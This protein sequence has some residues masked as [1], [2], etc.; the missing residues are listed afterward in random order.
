MSNKP[1]ELLPIQFQSEVNK[2]FFENTVDQ[3]FQK[4]NTEVLDGFIGRKISGTDRANTSNF[5]QQNDIGRNFYSLEP[6]FTSIDATSGTPGN[7][8]FYE[9]LLFSL[10]SYNAFVNNH[11]RLFKAKE[12][13]YS[14]PIDIDKFVNYQNYFWIPDDL[15]IVRIYGTADSPINIDDI[16]GSKTFVAPNGTELLNGS[17]VQFTGN[18][19]SGSTFS[20]DTTYQVEG[21]GQHIQ[22]IVPNPQNK[23]SAY[24][25]FDSVAWDADWDGIGAYSGAGLT[26]DA[27]NINPSLYSFDNQPFDA[28]SNQRSADYLVL[29][30]GAKNN[31]PWSRLNYWYH[32]DT[33]KQSRTVSIQIPNPWDTSSYDSTS[34]D[35]TLTEGSARGSIP[36]GA[37]RAS[38]PI[39]EFN[40]DLELY[41][42][43]KTHTGFV[44]LVIN[45]PKNQ[46]DGKIPMGYPLNGTTTAVGKQVIFTANESTPVVYDIGE[47]SNSNVTVTAN[48]NISIST[49]DTFV[50]SEGADI[51]A[52]YYW[53]GSAWTKAQFKSGVNLAPKFNLYD[54]N[55]VCLSNSTVYPSN[56]FKGNEIFSY[57]L[58]AANSNDS[59]LG[60]K[61]D[62]RAGKY[63]S[64]ILYENDIT[65]DSYIYTP[66][67]S[68]TSTVIPGYYYAKDNTFS[69]DGNSNERF[70][71]SWMPN[72]V[73]SYYLKFETTRNY[74]QGTTVE[75]NNQFFEANANVTAGAFDIG[76]WNL[77]EEKYSVQVVQDEYFID[78]TN[79]DETRFDISATPYNNDVDVFL[80]ARKLIKNTD[81]SIVANTN[82]IVLTDK[83]NYGDLL[84]I[85]TQTKGN[86]DFGREGRFVIPSA[87]EKNTENKSVTE[88]TTSDVLNHFLSIISD[89]PTFKGN[90]LGVNNFINS[91]KIHSGNNAKIRQTF[92]D[93]PS[94]MFFARGSVANFIEALRYSEVEYTK[95][96]NRLSS[97]TKAYLE[98][99]DIQGK[100]NAQL[101]EEIYSEIIT[102]RTTNEAFSR[103]YMLPWGTEFESV[104]FTANSSTTFT[105]TVDA[106]LQQMNNFV[107]VY[108]NKELLVADTDYTVSSSV[109]VAI[110]LTTVSSGDTIE[111]K[112][113]QD[114]N[115]SYIP[116]TPSTLGLHKLYKPEFK[117]DSTYTDS[118]SVIQGHDGSY[119]AR[120]NTK[121]DDIILHFEKLVYNSVLQ[122]VRDK[123]TVNPF[124]NLDSVKPSYFSNTDYSRQEINT[125]L[126]EGFSRWASQNNVDFVTNSTLDTNN[127]FTWNYGELGHWR[128]VYEYYYDTQTPHTT[129][130]E[131]FGFSKKPSWWES[132]YG[133]TVTTSSTALWNNV[134]TGYIPQGDRKGYYTRYKRENITSNLPVDSSGNLLAPNVNVL[135]GVVSSSDDITKSWRFGDGAPAEQA[136][137][138][139]S[140]YPFA[141]VKLLFLARPGE[142]IKYYNDVD[143]II[144]PSAMPQQLVD[145]TTRKRLSHK[146]ITYYGGLESDNET[147][148]L[149]LGFSAYVDSW[150]LYQN[151]DSARQ[152]QEVLQATDVKL[153]H[154]FSGY[155][156]SN[157]LKVYSDKLSIDGFS[158]GERVPA[159]DIYT[160]LHTS[161]VINR[162]FYTGVQVTK[163][164]D[165]YQVRG[166]DKGSNVFKILE[167]D[168]NGGSSEIKV[169]GEPIIPSIFSITG[170]YNKDDIISYNGNYYKAK[171]SVTAGDFNFDN[172]NQITDLPTEG[173]QEGT[174]YNNTTGSV[175]EIQYGHTFSSANATFDFLISLGRYQESIGFE[176]GDYDESI[177]DVGNW[178]YSAKQ[179]LFWVDSNPATNTVSAFSPNA[180]KLRFESAIGTVNQINKFTKGI[181]SIVDADGK[182]LEPKECEISRSG[183]YLEI[184][185]PEGKSIYGVILQTSVT[186]HAMVI[187]NKSV[188][189][190][191]IL[192]DIYGIRQERLRLKTQRSLEWDGSLKAPGYIIQGRNTLPNFDSLVE[193]T[194][195]YH[196]LFDNP[197]LPIKRTLARSVFGY[198]EKDYLNNLGIDDDEQ[199]ELL[200]GA[201]R[202][203]GTAR[204]INRILRSD[205]INKNKDFT[206]YEEWAVKQGVFGD[207]GSKKSFDIILNKKD[208]IRDQ[209]LIE[210][211]YPESV[212]GIV[213]SIDI[214]ER[215]TQY[216]APPIVE[217]DPP[218]LAVS[219]LSGSGTG[220]A[221][222]TAVLG[223]D[224]TLSSITMDYKGFGYDVAPNV[225]IITGN[226]YVSKIDEVLVNGLAMSSSRVPHPYSNVGLGNIQILDHTVSANII[227]NVAHSTSLSNLVG[228]INTSISSVTGANVTAATEFE[229]VNG[230]M[231]L[232]LAGY[233]FT[234]SDSDGGTTLSY[235][236]LT[237]GRYQPK[238]KFKIEVANNT[239][240]NNIVTTIDGTN[241]GTS[242][243]SFSD[244]SRHTVNSNIALYN[245]YLANDKFSVFVD[246]NDVANNI[247]T[248]GD[249]YEYV[250]V[251]VDGV[252]IYNDSDYTRLTVSNAG[253]GKANIHLSN[254][255]SQIQFTTS[256]QIK[257]IEEA[258]ITFDTSLTSDVPGSNVEVKVESDDKLVAIPGSTRTYA[259]DKDDPTDNVVTIDID[260]AKR[261][262]K[263][264]TTQD[265]N[266][267]LYPT[268]RFTKGSSLIKNSGFVHKDNVDIQVF[269]INHFDSE[270]SSNTNILLN[271]ND[272]VHM[273]KGEHDNFDVYQLRS[274]QSR[275]QQN[276]FYLR[277][278]EGATTTKLFSPISLQEFND[279]NSI[280]DPLNKKYY[281]NTLFLKNSNLAN[282][283]VKYTNE[284]LVVDNKSIYRGVY[285]PPPTTQGLVT[286]IQPNR[287]A[288]IKGVYPDTTSEFK[289]ISLRLVNPNGDLSVASNVGIAGNI[290]GASNVAIG[291]EKI[292]GIEDDSVIR[293]YGDDL[294][295][296]GLSNG[297]VKS[298]N[299]VSVVHDKN[300]V[301][302]T[303]ANCNNKFGQV[304]GLG[305]INVR[306]I[307]TVEGSSNLVDGSY[308]V[309]A[310]SS[311]LNGT[312]LTVNV[313]IASS[314]VSSIAIVNPGS[315][316]VEDEEIRIPETS[317]GGSD[318]NV[319]V[320]SNITGVRDDGRVI[321]DKANIYAVISNPVTG[322]SNATI[323]GFTFGNKTVKFTADEIQDFGNTND[324]DVSQGKNDTSMSMLNVYGD[325]S[326]S[327]VNAT[328]STFTITSANIRF[329]DASVTRSATN[330]KLVSIGANADLKGNASLTLD[331]VLPTH[332]FVKLDSSKA[333][334]FYPLT[335]NTSN[336]KKYHFYDNGFVS[337]VNGNTAFFT[338]EITTQY[339]TVSSYDSANSQFVLGNVT[340][341]ALGT[342]FANV[343]FVQANTTVDSDIVGLSTKRKSLEILSSTTLA[344]PDTNAVDIVPSF[345][346]SV[347]NDT[348]IEANSNVTVI[349]FPTTDAQV[350]VDQ[351]I[352]DMATTKQRNAGISDIPSA[353]SYLTTANNNNPSLQFRLDGQAGKLTSIDDVTIGFDIKYLDDAQDKAFKLALED[354]TGEDARRVIEHYFV[355]EAKKI[356]NPSLENISISLESVG[357]NEVGYKLI[358]DGSV[359]KINNETNKQVIGSVTRTPSPVMVHSTTKGSYERPGSGAQSD[360]EIK[361]EFSDFHQMPKTSNGKVLE[362]HSTV[363]RINPNSN[364]TIVDRFKLLQT[365]G[366][367]QLAPANETTL[368]DLVTKIN[369]GQRGFDGQFVIKIEFKNGDSFTYDPASNEFIGAK[370]C[371]I[372]VNSLK[373]NYSITSNEAGLINDIRVSLY[374][375]TSNINIAHTTVKETF[376]SGITVEDA[377]P[378]NDLTGNVKCVIWSKDSETGDFVFASNFTGRAFRPSE[379]D[380][381]VTVGKLVSSDST[382][383]GIYNNF[384]TASVLNNKRAHN[385]D[386]MA[387]RI[388]DPVSYDPFVLFGTDLTPSN[389]KYLAVRNSG[390]E[391][392][393]AV[394]P[395]FKIQTQS[396]KNDLIVF[397]DTDGIN[398]AYKVYF[399]DLAFSGSSPLD[400]TSGF[401]VT[402]IEADK[403]I[404][405]G[406]THTAFAD[407]YHT[408]GTD[409][410]MIVTD[411]DGKHLLINQNNHNLRETDI[412]M[413]NDG[414]LTNPLNNTRFTVNQVQGND[415]YL[416][417]LNGATVPTANVANFKVFATTGQ[418][419]MTTEK[420]S[421]EA[422][423]FYSNNHKLL[424]GMQFTTYADSPDPSSFNSATFTVNEAYSTDSFSAE[425]SNISAFTND[426]ANLTYVVNSDKLVCNFLGRY[427]PQQDQKLVVYDPLDE[428][429]LHDTILTANVYYSQT[430]DEFDIEGDVAFD[431]PTP[432]TRTIQS[433]TLV[434][435]HYE[436]SVL[437]VPDHGMFRHTHITNAVATST[438]DANNN[439]TVTVNDVTNFTIGSNVTFDDA[440]ISHTLS[441]NTFV[442]IDQDGENNTF[443]ITDAN[444]TATAN[445]FRVTTD[446]YITNKER[447]IQ[448]GNT[449]FYDGFANP[450]YVTKDTISFKGRYKGTAEGWIT[451]DAMNIFVNGPVNEL[452]G[453][454]LLITNCPQEYY[455]RVY[456]VVS[457]YS[458][459]ESSNIFVVRGFAQNNQ[460][461]NLANSDTR[462][463]NTKRNRIRVNG[464]QIN[465]ANTDSMTNFVKSMNAEML[466]REGAIIDTEDGLH[467]GFLYGKRN[468]ELD[469]MKGTKY[470]NVPTNSS[471]LK[472]VFDVNENPYADPTGNTVLSANR[473]VPLNSVILEA[474]GPASK[475]GMPMLDVS[476]IEG[477]FKSQR[478]AYK[479]KKKIPYEKRSTNALD[480][481]AKNST[482]L[483]EHEKWTNG[484]VNGAGPV[485]PRQ[486]L[487]FKIRTYNKT[488]TD[489]FINDATTQ[490]EYASSPINPAFPGG[491]FPGKPHPGIPIGDPHRP[492]H[493]MYDWENH[494]WYQH[495]GRGEP[496]FGP[497]PGGG[498]GG[499]GAADGYGAGDWNEGGN[500]NNNGDNGGNGNQEG[501]GEAD[502][503]VDQQY[504]VE[505]AGNLCTQSGEILEFSDGTQVTL[506]EG[507]NVEQ[508]AALLASQNPNYTYVTNG[509]NQEPCEEL[510]AQS[511]GHASVDIRF[512]D[513]LQF[514]GGDNKNRASRPTYRE[515]IKDK[516]IITSKA[517]SRHSWNEWNM[518]KFVEA[519]MAIMRQE[520]I[521]PNRFPTKYGKDK[522]FGPTKGGVWI[523]WEGT[524]RSEIQILGQTGRWKKNGPVGY[525]GIGKSHGYIFFR[526]PREFF[527][528]QNYAGAVLGWKIHQK[529]YNI[530]YNK[531]TLNIGGGGQPVI[532]FPLFLSNYFQD[533]G[534]DGS[535]F[536]RKFFSQVYDANT[537]TYTT[538]H[539]RG[540]MSPAFRNNSVIHEYPR[541]TATDRCP[542]PVDPGAAVGT[543]QQVT[544]KRFLNS[545]KIKSNL[546]FSLAK[547]CSFGS[548]SECAEYYPVNERNLTTHFD[549]AKAKTE[550][551][552][553]KQQGL[554]DDTVELSADIEDPRPG[555]A[556]GEFATPTQLGI[557]TIYPDYIANKLITAREQ[558]N[559]KHKFVNGR[560]VGQKNIRDTRFV[561]LEPPEVPTGQLQDGSGFGYRIG[562]QLVATG[563]R[564][565]TI[566]EDDYL[567]ASVDLDRA[568]KL[569]DIGLTPEGN[570]VP[571]FD[572]LTIEQIKRKLT[573]EI[574]DTDANPIPGVAIKPVFNVT[575][576]Y[577]DVLPENEKRINVS[578]SGI[579]KIPYR[580]YI[581]SGG[582]TTEN[583]DQPD[584]EGIREQYRNYGLS[585]ISSKNFRIDVGNPTANVQT[586]HLTNISGQEKTY[587]AFIGNT[588]LQANFC[589]VGKVGF[590]QLF[591]TDSPATKSARL[592]SFD[593]EFDKTYNNDLIAVW[594]TQGQ[595]ELETHLQSLSAGTEGIWKMVAD[596]SNNPNLE[597]KEHLLTIAMLN[598]NARYMQF[599][600]FKDHRAYF[601]ILT[602]G[603][604]IPANQANQGWYEYDV[605]NLY[606]PKNNSFRKVTSRFY[607]VP[608]GTA[609]DSG[610]VG[611]TKVNHTS[612]SGGTVDIIKTRTL[613]TTAEE[614]RLENMLAFPEDTSFD[615]ASGVVTKDPTVDNSFTLD[616]NIR[617]ALINI[618]TTGDVSQ[619]SEQLDVLIIEEGIY[620]NF[621]RIPLT[622]HKAKGIEGE[623]D[624]KTP[625]KVAEDYNKIGLKNYLTAFNKGTGTKLG[626]SEAVIYTFSTRNLPDN[627]KVMDIS[628]NLQWISKDPSEWGMVWLQTPDGARLPILQPLG[629]AEQ[630][631][632]TG[633]F[634][635]DNQGGVFK[636]YELTNRSEGKYHNFTISSSI[637]AQ[638]VPTPENFPTDGRRIAPEPGKHQRYYRGKDRHGL[639]GTVNYDRPNTPANSIWSTENIIREYINNYDKTAKGEWRVEITR[640]GRNWDDWKYDTP[641]VETDA[642]GNETYQNGPKNNT[643]F[644]PKLTLTYAIFPEGALATS[645]QESDEA[646]TSF[647]IVNQGVYS[648][649]E[650]QNFG[651]MTVKSTGLIVPAS[652]LSGVTVRTEKGESLDSK[653]KNR[654]AKF[655]VTGVNSL[656]SISKLRITDRGTYINFPPEMERGV[657]LKYDDEFAASLAGTRPEGLGYG[658]RVAMTS[659]SKINCQNNP[660]IF[661]APGDNIA[662]LEPIT[663][664]IADAINQAAGSNVAVNAYS[665]DI[666]P[667]VSVLDIR[668][669]NDGIEFTP[670]NGD[671]NPWKLPTGDIDKD[672]IGVRALDDFNNA[673]DD[674]NNLKQFGDIIDPNLGLTF[675]RLKELGLIQEEGQDGFTLINVTDAPTITGLEQVVTT[676]GFSYDI[677]NLD[678]T[679][680]ETLDTTANVDPMYMQSVLFRN[681]I[682]MD[683]N[684]AN[685]W[686]T[687]F[688]NTGSVY[689]ENG[690]VVY[691][692]SNLVESDRLNKAVIYDLD[693]NTTIK[694]LEYIDPFKDVISSQAKINL[695][696]IT[697][698][699]PVV[700]KNNGS[701]FNK[702]NVGELWWDTSTC[703]SLWYEQ[704][705][706]TYRSRNWGKWHP[707]SSFDVYEW[708][709]STFSPSEYVANGGVGTPKDQNNFLLV[710]E[711]DL[712]RNNHRNVYYFWVKGKTT[713]P[714][715]ADRTMSADTV[716]RH[717]EDPTALGLPFYAP[718]SNTTIMV[719]NTKRFINDSQV[720]FQVNYTVKDTKYD[721]RHSQWKLYREGDRSSN[722][723]TSIIN[724]MIDSICGYDVNNKVVPD[725]SLNE[726]EKY[727]LAIRPK[728]SMFKNIKE[729]R[730]VFAQFVNRESYKTE[731][732]DKK[733]ENWSKGISTNTYW[734]TTNWKLPTFDNKIKPKL[735]LDQYKKLN[736][737]TG[738][739]DGDVI[740]VNNKKDP[741]KDYQWNQSTSEFTHV[742]TYNAGYKL[743]D[744]VF[745]SNNS[746]TLAT[747]LRQFIDAV[748]NKLYIEDNSVLVNECFFAMLHYV[749]VEQDEIDWAFK[750]TYFNI[751]QGAD[752][753][754]QTAINKID[755]FDNVK[756]YINEFK[757]FT[758]K[759]RDFQDVKSVPLEKAINEST[760]FD[761]P[762][763]QPNPNNDPIVLD[764]NNVT[765]SNIML[766]DPDYKHWFSNYNTF[767]SKVRR[768]NE[769]IYIDRTSFVISESRKTDL[770]SGFS[771]QNAAERLFVYD[772]DISKLNTAIQNEGN[773]YSASSITAFRI[774]RDALIKTKVGADFKGLSIDAGKFVENLID[775][776]GN[777]A[778]VDTLGWDSSAWDSA[779]YDQEIEV[780]NYEGVFGD[781]G[782]L[783]LNGAQYKGLA[784]TSFTKIDGPDRPEELVIIDPKENLIINVDAFANSNLASSSF[785]VS[786][787]AHVDMFGSTNYYRLGQGNATTISANVTAKDSDI[788][789]ANTSIFGVVS[790]GDPGF[791]FINDEMIKI[792]RI[793]GNVLVGVERGFNGTTISSHTSADTIFNANSSVILNEQNV[794]SNVALWNTNLTVTN[795]NVQTGAGFLQADANPGGY[796]G[797]IS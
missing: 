549:P 239:T 531:Y 250:S 404:I 585:D 219:G 161:G 598:W 625:S 258:S 117:T 692:E 674:L 602:I 508:L 698:A 307:T 506:G 472:T 403:F 40:K 192:N 649:A 433:N 294:A 48:S 595:P 415:S 756:G 770:L 500:N 711:Y 375:P 459:D 538:R 718:V 497:F 60:F 292:D 112:C 149:K 264:P 395:T 677:Y 441:G 389:L 594:D 396:I 739:T 333:N 516:G 205:A 736:F 119:T 444:A 657:P 520:D 268:K 458:E 495:N 302:V 274:L 64:D 795:A 353:D 463:V 706:V 590:G 747:E 9:D 587:K 631:N 362:Y 43:G 662:Q 503:N 561:M 109:P 586:L 564:P 709:R 614:L 632:E 456:P 435:K 85:K 746:I 481:N 424:T 346:V 650:I 584:Y 417:K 356:D 155:I 489:Q 400:T 201:I 114:S 234:L 655:I 62:R 653:V 88:F 249:N 207:I 482:V 780:K 275:T 68:T 690:N 600:G 33:V 55:K 475:V 322:G 254:I 715:R 425:V 762:P 789:V 200:T 388:K 772:A 720:A 766:T 159:E 235:L 613:T 133:T 652:R 672:L 215:N 329:K 732:T 771:P 760:D 545:I 730:R 96:K 288:N 752:E 168:I 251:F 574:I 726:F 83:A 172:W 42:Y 729:A 589:M 390:Y 526:K 434:L 418:M 316:F 392:D 784:G 673:D 466:D 442:I 486:P 603:T 548:I 180:E 69:E 358:N 663:D 580:D 178:L 283:V 605:K 501:G 666:N 693:D 238:Q 612:T 308:V 536:L 535:S 212:T 376:S 565:K 134:A 343:K 738:L 98:N 167:S 778:L 534:G 338:G 144:K 480:Y 285:N 84:T 290:D 369:N 474:K 573:F 577:E 627:A 722:I 17:F 439:V 80:N 256:S 262:V 496:G 634:G 58:N 712:G 150:L 528:E 596:Y 363:P 54:E 467:L 374:D 152:V 517:A 675:D 66:T 432:I 377:I 129:P 336:P 468:E 202:R 45:D 113:Y 367:N 642:N 284:Q 487:G 199:I 687:D 79:K 196:K 191:T 697:E 541:T 450:K 151:F 671:F 82:G 110:N 14:P 116:Y 137:K 754:E 103:T 332:T 464:S 532:S 368:N 551:N 269:D 65:K 252:Q 299:V 10:R 381:G 4:S 357:G 126:F 26:Y 491:P 498:A 691:R 355:N 273:A 63:S 651:Q 259:I 502:I 723:S 108:K 423:V 744:S 393:N 420:A 445:I 344:L 507:C 681:D 530:G 684:N 640:P 447:V 61:V 398:N 719:Q 272:V 120:V 788:T 27:D 515:D 101:F 208:F 11:N 522:Y 140:A 298:Y 775:A 626:E 253:S 164:A 543:L 365:F 287:T 222:A 786:Y 630:F 2:T 721:K 77:L 218:R 620:N 753:L 678:N 790:P 361:L 628:L 186:E 473:Y 237:A 261:F 243:Y 616:S 624:Y 370:N 206:I 558:Q 297:S 139:T 685:V 104:S 171:D 229:D 429:G 731:L 341:T 236:N 257:I 190:D 661:P 86:I 408:N 279:A 166:Y 320:F 667:D 601:K 394:M 59:V 413:F 220:T 421:A 306:D 153:G 51:G 350:T 422:L 578:P 648:Q 303:E 281:D 646:I 785:T 233:D 372:K 337:T 416:I 328:A 761:K 271:N 569:R 317:L 454:S 512:K 479:G 319:F 741:W 607:S 75:Y 34:Y 411:K 277:Q 670:L 499:D 248:S 740:R 679:T 247:S 327:N 187:N 518:T 71:H 188:F 227:A 397:A 28:V 705:N 426:G 409:L 94:A 461:L 342:N 566:Q 286:K 385:V 193:A 324:V 460:T 484:Y 124:Y 609:G 637:D 100:S 478:T 477:A 572:N 266:V 210:L 787:R 304:T 213:S 542:P 694:E 216:F 453:D 46:I 158:T 73:P 314:E 485:D 755:A 198:F 505:L 521:D 204:S 748:F 559:T 132:E 636:G 310:T 347:V 737:L 710:K 162:Q 492:Y 592:K 107:S 742:R 701:N 267:K 53:N 224:G 169:G 143:S 378:A 724:K 437:H 278:P 176:F 276:N 242:Y 309:S 750:T 128:S 49:G 387:L 16:P 407:Y 533:G 733:Y 32:I 540:S 22:L 142:F 195:N 696:Y 796:L 571:G 24:A 81:Y 382:A 462:Y 606:D 56:S 647:E 57:K 597:E 703:R 270:I 230:P 494:L 23:I 552:K 410:D 599:L 246:F 122:S 708:T 610:G 380:K 156:N 695:T 106:N 348:T 5:I 37:V 406:I 173:S 471:G 30:R 359:I 611:H 289:L 714:N 70:L 364:A 371:I 792:S 182:T 305:N 12:F 644:A 174:Y 412:V 18:H 493:G 225:S 727:G 74:K 734:E 330:S 716:A 366:R 97:R 419:T 214:I 183:R 130:W 121:V 759:L 639:I 41:N 567:F 448:I 443:T 774:E 654:V 175:K 510:P 138:K 638:T 757:P 768:F 36:E 44:E 641:I 6:T 618:K 146:Q 656:G 354:A 511:E 557:G 717:I 604:I 797:N 125:M 452:N 707:G 31:N 488:G 615:S 123:D 194:R 223:T 244:S 764:V 562:D 232:K 165:G 509:N 782:N 67:G 147:R 402:N 300:T 523:E 185:P 282:L 777:D 704:G 323:Q 465:L 514:Y 326:L 52:E 373:V 339:A 414:S 160:N 386:T 240:I 438:P 20:P 301:T 111:I 118:L 13:T 189:A 749:N 556:Y 430:E 72:D 349:V 725:P 582:D 469:P 89:Q 405:D 519:A 728:Q 781:S 743:K 660:P 436:D 525:K 547:G 668:T 228:I 19:V 643:V 527:A 428:L 699:D 135:S 15:D 773:I 379:I 351:L 633:L 588:S 29:Q 102:T 384:H 658:G 399:D 593:A 35:Y 340:T 177:G 1:Y 529:S 90:A 115:P 39:V 617:T 78:N 623:A 21:V 513:A 131:M 209:Q 87:L 170:T 211:K 179:F 352:D 221:L 682:D 544:E 676:T 659:R 446:A 47:D 345:S 321:R 669:P 360:T 431:L 318:S 490:N 635:T 575:H 449:G 25:T 280:N 476:E 76:D 427:L 99:N 313:T 315:D 758:S 293:F 93:L 576:T 231:L 621:I 537:R 197:T 91:E 546:P 295:S 470:I 769:T 312:G 745:T 127:A 793:E 791:A 553:L 263:R 148:I 664:A 184:T 255:S 570:V 702:S 181:P 203:K 334:A 554:Y 619:D 524:H 325:Y 245:Q 8:I 665:Y 776:A 579:A 794:N 539:L 157:D 688:Q 136:W 440:N 779:S 765:H 50:I 3:L 645:L 700:Y 331:T 260:D 550:F 563:G 154:K 622:I 767:D 7:F 504:V 629:Q 483:K 141:L 751:K 38:R 391:I 335:A 105:T 401:D 265:L 92:S 555:A 568:I 689:F 713:V 583:W 451:N 383:V 455:N 296:T 686:V 783:T 241:V 457:S 226:L 95:F 683:R 291:F 145:K 217:V 163:K 735:V 680:V 763:Y 560:F 608:V 591:D 311:E 581:Y